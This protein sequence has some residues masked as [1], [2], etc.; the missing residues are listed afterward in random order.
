MLYYKEDLTIVVGVSPVARW[1][2]SSSSSGSVVLQTV[3]IL[4]LSASASSQHAMKSSVSLCCRLPA[5]ISDRTGT[6][7]HML[8]AWV[9]V[10]SARC[11]C[12]PA[13]EI[14]LHCLMWPSAPVL[15]D[16]RPVWISL[17]RGCVFKSPLRRY[18]V[19]NFRNHDFITVR[20]LSYPWEEDSYL[21]TCI[22][23]SR[24]KSGWLVFNLWYCP[25]FYKRDCFTWKK[26]QH[27]PVNPLASKLSLEFSSDRSIN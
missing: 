15:L 13:A 20:A 27:I 10:S 21:D 11:H 14:N 26:Q 3:Q 18:L 16:Q 1:N 9:N 19:W 22:S 17:R 24:L 23:I 25:F 12:L 7:N 8:S 4:Q 5:V 2:W 6:V